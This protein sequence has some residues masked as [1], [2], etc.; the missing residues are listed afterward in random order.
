M[1]F[2]LKYEAPFGDIDK[3]HSIPTGTWRHKRPVIKSR[4]CSQCG[5]CHLYC[6]VGS[7]I[8]EEG[9]FNV[10]LKFCKGCGI[11]AKICPAHAIIM[12]EEEGEEVPRA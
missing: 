10:D 6:P 3:I 2:K 12:V 9:G 8:E 7:L 5:W 4:K 1:T 11:C